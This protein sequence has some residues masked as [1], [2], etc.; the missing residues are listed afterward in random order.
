MS[1]QEFE[2]FD[3]SSIEEKWNTKELMLRWFGEKGKIFYIFIIIKDDIQEISANE[4]KKEKTIKSKLLSNL[5][6]PY[7]ENN[8]E[9]ILYI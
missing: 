5:Q 8:E 9:G 7:K 6:E 2:L 4:S 1:N 3:R